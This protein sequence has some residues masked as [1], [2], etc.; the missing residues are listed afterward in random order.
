MLKAILVGANLGHDGLIDY[1]MEEL[2]N[3]AAA[4]NIE[5]VYSMTQSLNKITSNFYIGK[6]KV[7]EVKQFVDNLDADMVIFNDEL[8]G[9]QVRNLEEIIELGKSGGAGNLVICEVIKIH[10]SQDVLNGDG[11]IDQQ[12]I[13]KQKTSM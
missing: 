3:L 6:G 4:S 13:V 10:I 9:S 12:K 8:S 5:V 2:E 1:S 7:D 11:M